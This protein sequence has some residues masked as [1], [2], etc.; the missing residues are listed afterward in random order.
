[1][2]LDAI[3]P[4]VF[5]YSIAPR[6]GIEM[7]QVD[8]GTDATAVIASSVGGA[9]HAI[10]AASEKVTRMANQTITMLREKREKVAKEDGSIAVRQLSP[11]W[12]RG[13]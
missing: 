3:Y 13:R 7:P 4:Q 12:A 11:G 1:M 5:A 9:A 6:L 2:N 10:Q 8:S